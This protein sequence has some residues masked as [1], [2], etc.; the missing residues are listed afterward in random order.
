MIT[1]TGL[2]FL[3]NEYEIK[4]YAEGQTTLFIPYTQI[5]SLLRPKTVVSQYLK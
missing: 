5:K 2:S 1:P 3:Y 4:S